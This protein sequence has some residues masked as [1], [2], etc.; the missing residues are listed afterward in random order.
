MLF[1]SQNRNAKTI[2]ASPSSQP[3]ITTIGML[4]VSGLSVPFE[5]NCIFIFLRFV[6]ILH[7]PREHIYENRKISIFIIQ[8]WSLFFMSRKERRA[9]ARQNKIGDLHHPVKANN[10][11][12]IAV[13]VIT[14]VAVIAT[15]FIRYSGQ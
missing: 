14:V 6:S 1:G 2:M 7:Y 10:G 8:E 11:V 9:K 3:P 12:L 5:Y 15:Y 4:K 13:A